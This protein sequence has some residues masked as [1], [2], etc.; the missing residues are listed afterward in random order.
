ML[1]GLLF[2]EREFYYIYFFTQIFTNKHNK[3]VI[4][5]HQIEK[6]WIWLTSLYIYNRFYISY[7]QNLLQRIWNLYNYNNITMVIGEFIYW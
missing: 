1:F 2:S 5:K 4:L 7:G 6:H 3:E